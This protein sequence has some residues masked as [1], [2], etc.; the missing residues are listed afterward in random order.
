LQIEKFPKRGWY[1]TYPH[2]EWHKIWRCVLIIGKSD[3]GSQ[4]IDWSINDYNGVNKTPFL[5]D[6]G[7]LCSLCYSRKHCC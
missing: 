1:I 2:N 7:C 6:F 4:V 3:K 5:D